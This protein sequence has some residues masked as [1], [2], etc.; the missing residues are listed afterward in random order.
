MPSTYY[1]LAREMVKSSDEAMD[2]PVI[3]KYATGVVIFSFAAIESFVNQLTAKLGVVVEPSGRCECEYPKI[4]NKI[5]AI[6]G[7]MENQQQTLLLKGRGEYQEF[8]SLRLARNFLI[9]YAPVEELMWESTGQ[10]F[11]TENLLR[12]ERQL[13][14]YYSFSEKSI[15]PNGIGT[16]YRIFNKECAKWAFARIAAFI[17]ALSEVSGVQPPRFTDTQ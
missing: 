2:I 6:L 13:K 17:G 16:Y 5:D 4:F 1:S 11:E 7:N 3:S 15:A 14:N 8:D 9:H 12:I 10:H